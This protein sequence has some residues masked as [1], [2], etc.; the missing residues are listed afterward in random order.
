MLNTAKSMGGPRKQTGWHSLVPAEVCTSVCVCMCKKYHFHQDLG[1]IWKTTTFLKV[2]PSNT[3]VVN[4]TYSI[5]HLYTH[6][7]TH[8]QFPLLPLSLSL[9]HPSVR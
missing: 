9:C 1:P 2:Y 8:S 5:T 3:L 7:H 4:A 6:I